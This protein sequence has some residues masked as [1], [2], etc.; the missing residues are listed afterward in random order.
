MNFSLEEA[1]ACGGTN[2][3][4]FKEKVKEITKSTSYLPINLGKLELLSFL[5][6]IGEGDE[7]RIIFAHH[8]PGSGSKRSY[9]EL[10]KLLQKGASMKLISEMMEKSKLM[11]R[12]EGVLYFT[13]E[14]LTVTLS[15]RTQIGGR[16]FSVPTVKRDEYISE[17]LGLHPS[18]GILMYREL[19]GVR[20]A[21]SVFSPKYDP[22]HQT[23]LLN[24]MDE[25]KEL[26]ETKFS[27]WT[28][29]H[30]LT[31]VQL[32]FEGKA[33]DI[34]AVYHLPDELVPGLL[35]S[36]SDTGY[37][38]LT[39]IGTLKIKNSYVHLEMFRQKHMGGLNEEDL[40]EDI[41]QK[42][43]AQYTQIPQ[44]LCELL[45]LP[46]E[47]PQEV[48]K[49]IFAQIGI[50][51]AV[52][53]KAS[54]SLLKQ[55]CAEF[56]GGYKNTAYNIAIAIMSMPERVEGLNQFSKECLAKAVAKAPFAD[57][58]KK[59]PTVVLTA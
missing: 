53:R 23:C 26:G 30:Q 7:K 55:L 6:V 27:A 36:T 49:S 24:I 1:F 10:K 39:C 4:G 57:Y 18:N 14:W 35:L 31:Q 32:E 11:L 33:K 9:I 46:V 56:G 45:M 3:Q 47:K 58:T 19:N 37:S 25:L 29:D 2:L 21:F 44:K 28:M 8:L 41:Q 42:I 50:T 54:D 5:E 38:S 22:M 59:E 48:I 34:A 17:V 51:K 52:G 16:Q 12:Y 15:N 13:S 20:K 43:F 40:L